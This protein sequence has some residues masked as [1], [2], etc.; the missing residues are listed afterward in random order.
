VAKPLARRAPGKL[1]PPPMELSLVP[2]VEL[3]GDG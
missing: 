3:R 1:E 2:G